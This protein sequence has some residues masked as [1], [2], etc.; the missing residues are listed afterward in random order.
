ML[1]KMLIHGL[2]AAAL[3]GSAAAVYAQAK[4]NP[5]WSAAATP[6]QGKDPAVAQSGDG[7]L[8]PA[9]ADV[10]DRGDERRPDARAERSRERDGRDHD[11]DDD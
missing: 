4:D 10:R 9:D 2:L 7:Y 8:R 5:G 1:G 6:E 3:I 11:D